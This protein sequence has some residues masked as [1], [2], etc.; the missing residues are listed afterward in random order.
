MCFKRLKWNNII[1]NTLTNAIFWNFFT[2]S[3]C[4]VKGAIF[5][6]LITEDTDDF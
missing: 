5:Q 3:L 6:I 4:L 2:I 1:N